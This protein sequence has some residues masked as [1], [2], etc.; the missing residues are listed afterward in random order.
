MK[1]RKIVI[2]SISL[3]FLLFSSLLSYAQ[4]YLWPKTEIYQCECHICG[5]S[6]KEM[7]EVKEM[8]YFNSMSSGTW[9]YDDTPDSMKIQYFG[10]KK[11]IMICPECLRKYGSEIKKKIN[12]L[13][14]K[15]IL[16]AIN[17]NEKMRKYFSEQRKQEQIDDI[18]R[19][20]EKL[21]NERDKM[22]GKKSE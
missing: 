15:L 5:K 2:V 6:I 11:E 14:D 4:S 8:V 16:Q 9:Y 20:I 17:E 21:K 18:K 1:T 10:I 7:R 13:W 19:K 3:S 12:L 22:Q